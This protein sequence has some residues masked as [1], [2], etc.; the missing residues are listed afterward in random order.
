M[1]QEA[2]PA[3]EQQP[4]RVGQVVE[5]DSQVEPGIWETVFNPEHCYHQRKKW[6]IHVGSQEK[7]EGVRGQKC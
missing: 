6:I 1:N 2:V 5:H 4:Q 3:T 7:T